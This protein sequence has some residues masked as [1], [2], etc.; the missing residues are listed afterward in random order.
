[1]T[2]DILSSPW[3]LVL[4]RMAAGHWTSHRHSPCERGCSDCTLLVT[5]GALRAQPCSKVSAPSHLTAA[6]PNVGITFFPTCSRTRG[7]KA[8]SL[9]SPKP[10][11]PQ[12]RNFTLLA[13]LLDHR[14]S[15][16][17]KDFSK[18]LVFPFL[19]FL[20]EDLFCF[21]CFPLIRQEG[22]QNT[23]TD[24]QRQRGHGK[25]LLFSGSGC[26]ACTQGAAFEIL[27][28]ASQALPQM[29]DHAYE[30]LF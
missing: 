28:G 10:A 20:S 16:P 3:E 21:P 27:H 29:V 12:I 8:H 9:L 1:M 19:F 14:P 25:H 24:W 30:H 7:S 26:L 11:P 4:G 2:A 15:Q 13:S 18:A 6:K 17:G 5:L 23:T 22:H